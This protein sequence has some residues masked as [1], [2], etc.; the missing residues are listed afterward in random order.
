MIAN[1]K[2]RNSKKYIIRI[3]LGILIFLLLAATGGFLYVYYNQDSIK[4]I[5]VAEIN[6]SLQTEI[7]V[8]DIEFSVFDKFPDASL[9]FTD[10]LAKDAVK[11]SVK[12]SVKGILLQA[13]SIFLEFNIL[14]L[15]YKKYRIKNIELKDAVIYLKVDKDGKD[16]FHC[17]KS[18]VKQSE[19]PFEFNLKNIKFKNVAISYINQLN[20]QYYDFLLENAV[21]K[22]NFSTDIQAVKLKGKLQI[23]HFQSENTVYLGK[24]KAD[25]DIEASVNTLIES[26]E[27]QKGDII[28]NDLGFT[29]NGSIFYATTNKNIQLFI[30]GKN[31]QLHHFIKE[32]PE[33]QQAYFSNYQS[34]GIFNIGIEIKGKYGGTALPLITA[35]FN[36]RNAEIFH[37]KTK[38]RLTN[39]N[40]LGRYSNGKDGKAENNS[41]SIQQFSAR[42]KNGKINASIT[43]SDFKNPFIQCIASVSMNLQDLHEF[44]KNDQ[45][46]AIQGNI[47]LDFNF[48]GKITKKA[49]KLSDFLNSQCSGNIR[50]NN[51]QLQLTN[52]NRNYKNIN[53]V[54]TFTNNDIEINSLTANI[55]SSDLSMKGYFKNVI[56]FV[57]LSNQKIEVN[58]DLYSNNTD[59]DE[60]IGTKNNTT[61]LKGLHF[62]DFYTFNLSL[63]T[64]NIKYK[65][66]KAAHLKGKLSYSNQVFK[67]DQLSMESM[68]G[69]L[70]G[71]MM[72]D[73]RQKN[74]FLISCDVNTVKVNTQQLFY[75]FENFGQH[76]MTSDNINGSITANVQFAAY[77]NAYMDVDKKTIWSKINL[78]IENGKL[79]NYQPLLKLSRFINVDDLKEVQFKTL[80]NQILIRNESIYIPAMD[81]V[82]SA[83][84]LGISGEHKFNNSINYHLNVLLSELNSKKRK[85]RKQQKQQAQQEFGFEEDDG[86]GKSKLF[87]KVSGTIDHP[88][89]NYDSK[90]LKDKI[91]IDINNEKKN[92]NTILKEEFRWLQRD[93]AD[94]IQQQRFKIQE[95][96]KY[97]IDWEDETREKPKKKTSIDSLPASKIKIKWEE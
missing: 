86:L 42:L 91:L 29:I 57:F 46:K 60:I 30:K 4:Q 14:D 90:S 75:V 15:Y 36:L 13:K 68:D 84:S 5:F 49:M 25:I 69:N 43:I 93:T 45:I 9:R 94:I 47:A 34:K 65:K 17:W 89:F 78:K 63:H 37:I 22:G 73:G 50:L 18:T 80:Q 35:N 1:G 40:M 19:T 48:K 39:V 27:I 16:N 70:N 59:L 8:K 71:S 11:D 23:N 79:L 2:T 67:A 3:L 81:I 41:L 53:G 32:L 38:A 56:P 61:T 51:V 28:F 58:A 74:K 95:K 85:L 83:I 92:L 55:S 33:E 24:G 7:S 82:S 44:I 64:R 87:L 62:S 21:A 52:D 72:L 31:I 54:F 88:V 66:F 6:K 10:V 26:V 97:I 12:D 77:F 76:N 20:H 96:G